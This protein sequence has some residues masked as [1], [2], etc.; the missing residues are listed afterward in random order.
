MKYV[1]ID[2]LLVYLIQICARRIHAATKIERLTH[3]HM[4][5][6]KNVDWMKRQANEAEILL[7]ED[8][9]H[10][11]GH[12]LPGIRDADSDDA[13]DDVLV[14]GCG[15]SSKGAEIRQVKTIEEVDYAHMKASN[16]TLRRLRAE[17]ESLLEIPLNK[18][19]R[20][21]LNPLAGDF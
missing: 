12:R 9:Y 17:L 5:A 15:F 6:T 1:L 14:N 2:I 18:R 16:V 19:A 8:S 7:S 3:K 11:K 21:G 13:E 20:V 10:K 4:I